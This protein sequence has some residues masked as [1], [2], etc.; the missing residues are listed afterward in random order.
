MNDYSLGV[1]HIAGTIKILGWPKSLF[2][3]FHNILL[4]MNFL[5]NP[6]FVGRNRL[7]DTENKLTVTKEESGEEVQ[8][9]PPSHIS[10]NFALSEPSWDQLEA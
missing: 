3:F 2:G 4:R 10:W 9:K 5:I 7:T 8:Y 1:W 6:V